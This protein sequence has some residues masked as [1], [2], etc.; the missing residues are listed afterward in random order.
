MHPIEHLEQVR[1]YLS[2]E[3]QE[4]AYSL[5]R[6]FRDGRTL[7]DRQKLFVEALAERGARAQSLGAVRKL[8]AEEQAELEIVAEAQER[9]G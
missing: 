3:D 4:A 2:E 5:C 6:Q 1:G 8:L 7:T 9:L